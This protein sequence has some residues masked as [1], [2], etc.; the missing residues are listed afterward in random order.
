VQAA[1]VVGDGEGFGTVPPCPVEDEDGMGE[2]GNEAIR[3]M[4]SPTKAATVRAIPAGGR[5]SRGC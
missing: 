3:G 1:D 2:E 4:V 5:F